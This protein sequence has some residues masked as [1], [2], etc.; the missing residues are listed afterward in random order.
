MVVA[1]IRALAT[2]LIGHNSNPPYTYRSI[3][4]TSKPSQF[5]TIDDLISHAI[6]DPKSK[7]KVFKNYVLSGGYD[8]AITDFKA[9]IEGS[10]TKVISATNGRGLMFF[11]EEGIKL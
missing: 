1:W 8:K 6:E 2:I 3:R 9:L 7:R 10:P 4:Y 11:N 5:L